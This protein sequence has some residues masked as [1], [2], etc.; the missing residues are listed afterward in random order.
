MSRLIISVRPAHFMNNA[1]IILKFFR[2]FLFQV[3]GHQK[4]IY[5]L[6]VKITEMLLIFISQVKN[7]DISRQW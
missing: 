3:F 5:L 6:V 2:K 4:L 7:S 1:L